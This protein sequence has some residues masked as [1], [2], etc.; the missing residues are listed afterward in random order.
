MKA[1]LL[2]TCQAAPS[3]EKHVDPEC[4]ITDVDGRRFL[5]EGTI[6][7]HPDAFRLVHGGFAEAADDECQKAADA[8]LPKS[9]GALRRN[10]D[11]LMKQ[12][13]EEQEEVMNEADMN[14]LPEDEDEEGGE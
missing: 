4:I 3:A 5:P 14:D 13:N 12:F 1:R 9:R 7:D 6:I 10:H 2:V 8:L 11:K